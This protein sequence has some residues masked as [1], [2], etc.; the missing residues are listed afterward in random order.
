MKN[1]GS[2]VP[3]SHSVFLKSPAFD[4]QLGRLPHVLE[5][6]LIA[7]SVLLNNGSGG[8]T[9]SPSACVNGIGPARHQTAE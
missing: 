9:L 4:D 7:P 1:T 8:L 2:R 6:P 3:R 5:R